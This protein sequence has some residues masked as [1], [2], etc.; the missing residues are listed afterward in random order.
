M[1]AHGL[2]PEQLAAE[3]YLRWYHVMLAV[4][5]SAVRPGASTTPRRSCDATDG[6]GHVAVVPGRALLHGAVVA[7]AYRWTHAK[8]PVLALAEQ[9]KLFE[10]LRHAHTHA[11]AVLRV[12]TARDGAPHSVC[13]VLPSL[14]Y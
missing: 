7:V 13:R 2:S 3:C 10:Q 1:R 12:R 8:R 5:G 4:R 11:R 9:R 14:P 6:S